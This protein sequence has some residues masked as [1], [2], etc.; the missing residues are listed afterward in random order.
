MIAEHGVKRHAL[1]EQ[2]RK[3]L[4][5]VLGEVSAA[6]VG[7]D[8][9]AGGNCKIEGRL[10]VGLEHLFG[11][12]ELVTFSCATIAYHGES[13]PSLYGC[14]AEDRPAR[15]NGAGCNSGHG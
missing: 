12:A 10:L 11:D 9:V 6:A 2:C 15:E 13:D 14:G 7:I 3:R 8:I 4:L 1:L 5:E